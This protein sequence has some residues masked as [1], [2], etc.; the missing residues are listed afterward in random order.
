[1]YRRR[2]PETL[3]DV[4]DKTG[5]M[6]AQP[7]KDKTSEI[8]TQTTSGHDRNIEPLEMADQDL[9]GYADEEEDTI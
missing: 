4:F 2:D 3:M 1:M 6:G 8:G 5:A 9:E 7:Q